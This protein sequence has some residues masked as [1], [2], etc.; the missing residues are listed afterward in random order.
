MKKLFAPSSLI[1]S[2]MLLAS[3][4]MADSA[5]PLTQAMQLQLDTPMNRIQLLGAHNAWNDS[6]ATWANQRWP[7][8]KLLDNGV[9]NIDLDLHWD[10]GTV[11]LCHQ[12]CSAI[13]AAA[14]S[15]PGELQK[16]AN[17]LA[18]HPKDI[19]WLDL[20]DRVNDQNAVEG[21]LRAAFGSLLYTPKDKPADR[22]ETPREMIA[23]GKRILVKGANHWYDGSLI[24]DGRTFATG[25]QDGW[26]SRQVK[27]FDAANCTQDGKALVSGLIYT[28][29]DSKLGK[30]ILPDSWVDQTGTIDTSNIARLFACGVN[31]VDADRWDDDMT[32]QAVWSWAAA[33]PNN[34]GGNEHCAEQSG[35]G[36]WND[37][38]C[39]T[40]H[41]FACQSASNMDD[42][43]V[44]SGS[45]AWEQGR[46]QCAAEFPGYRFA[47]PVNSFTNQRLMAASRGQ[48][49]WLNYSDKAREGKWES[50]LDFPTQ[51]ASGNVVPNQNQYQTLTI[52]G[53]GALKVT[54]AAGLQ[55]STLQVFDGNR[56]LQSVVSGSQG[57]TS[58]VVNDNS[59]IVQLSP[60]ASAAGSASVQI[61]ATGVSE[62]PVWR[63]LVNGKGKCLDLEGRNT[64]N[65]AVVHHWSCHGANTQKWWQDAQGRIHSQA[66][67]NRCVTAQNSGNGNGTAIVLQDC[68]SG[69]NQVWLRGAGNSLRPA[70]APNKAIDIKDA[71]WGAF[72]GQD[73][74]LWDGQNSWGQS[75]GWK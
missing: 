26:N 58:F 41:R 57:A 50:Y 64:N 40:S 74:H 61:E 65:G 72:D 75:W 46:A 45:G 63:S 2:L 32:A 11:K 4:A 25:A 18:A 49:V 48:T 67:P 5:W 44:T 14:D 60:G 51:W 54:L 73:A 1:I 43:K 6:S 39:S 8:D 38:S 22:W 47:A 55:G 24:W 35:N 71:Y 3:S 66:S 21:P 37:A 36:R 68:G 70:H 62:T 59:V 30:D 12:D 19:L 52:P 23:K 7:L 29:S 27:Y 34:A 17:W 31:S 56:N 69:A 13:Y 20:E 15:Y 9:R 16:I 10:G 28:L 42:W 53:A 33:E